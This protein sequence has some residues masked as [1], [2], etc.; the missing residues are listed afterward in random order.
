MPQSSLV[1][2]T[3]HYLYVFLASLHGMGMSYKVMRKRVMTPGQAQSQVSKFTK[4]A[5]SHSPYYIGLAKKFIW[6]FP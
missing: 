4:Y 5:I 2:A 1:K 6:I 3:A